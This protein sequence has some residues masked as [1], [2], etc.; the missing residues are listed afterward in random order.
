MFIKLSVLFFYRRLFVGRTFNIAS[1]IMIGFTIAW[2]I[3]F[4][5]GLFASCPNGVDDF[6][7]SLETAK[8]YCAD[9]FSLESTYAATDVAVDL[10]IIAIPIPY[11][12][13]TSTPFR[14][15]HS[16]LPQKIYKGVELTFCSFV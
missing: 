2:G 11:V 1:W 5:I 3:A 9:V 13:F 8:L 4:F 16:N 6:F 15:L 10:A 7:D 12:F 14:F